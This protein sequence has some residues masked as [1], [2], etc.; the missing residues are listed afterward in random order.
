[1]G[2]QL[3][4]IDWSALLAHAPAYA[5]LLFVLPVLGLVALKMF[6]LT[7]ASAGPKS[8]K[9]WVLLREQDAEGIP[10]LAW[11]KLEKPEV[12]A[13]KRALVQAQMQRR[14]SWPKA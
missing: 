6:L 7:R 8:A 10:V 13:R 4:S 9:E 14:V 11:S 1:M 12:L 3:L 5:L 2:N